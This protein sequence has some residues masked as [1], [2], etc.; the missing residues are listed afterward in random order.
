MNS[1]PYS[2]SQF[3]VYRRHKMKFLRTNC[4]FFLC[5]STQYIEDSAA[6]YKHANHITSDCLDTSQS[7]QH[8]LVDRGVSPIGPR[9]VI[10]ITLPAGCYTNQLQ[11][12]LWRHPD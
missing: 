12:Q 6:L 8:S 4:A 7:M 9:Q 3:F 11:S 5:S 1:D 2:G 10:G